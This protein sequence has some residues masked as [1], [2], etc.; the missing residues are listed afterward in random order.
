[1]ENWKSVVGVVGYAVSDLG[2][3]KSTIPRKGGRA[4]VNDGLLTGWIQEV[5]SGYKRQLVAFRQDKKTIIKRVHHVV[6]DAFI[7]LR[8]F[9]MEALHKN[10]DSLDNRLTNL[11]WGTHS[12]NMQDSVRHGTKS[13]PPI[14]HGEKHHNATLTTADV[15]RI[16]G[17]VFVRGTQA[18]LSRD[19]G[20]ADITIQRIRLS[21]SRKFS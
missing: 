16:R 2:R 1:M 12:D 15:E 8:P 20:V 7:G 17:T 3:I 6:L 13:K 14:H 11:R 9:G 4:M 5:R 21:K 19:Y 18:K 10:G